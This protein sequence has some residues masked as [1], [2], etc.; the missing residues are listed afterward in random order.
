MEEPDKEWSAPP[1]KSSAIVLQPVDIA[2]WNGATRGPEPLERAIQR[3]ERGPP[4]A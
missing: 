2:S 1:L 3:L 4:D